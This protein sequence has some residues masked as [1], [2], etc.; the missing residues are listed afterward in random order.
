MAST[1][2]YSTRGKLRKNFLSGEGGSNEGGSNESG[3]NEEGINEGGI[4]E[5]GSKTMR[6][7]VEELQQLNQ[8]EEAKQLE[9]LEALKQRHAKQFNPKGREN[10]DNTADKDAEEDTTISLSQAQAMNTEDRES[11]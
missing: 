3:S 4:N 1:R 11:G 8:E 7:L 2:W 9:Q 10:D 5:S 6:E